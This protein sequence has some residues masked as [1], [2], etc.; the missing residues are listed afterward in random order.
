MTRPRRLPL[1]SASTQG[2][3]Q[4]WWT[5]RPPP[6]YPTSDVDT[7]GSLPLPAVGLG[8][9]STVGTP[10][11]TSS[12]SEWTSTGWPGGAAGPSGAN[13]AVDVSPAA[14][15]TVDPDHASAAGPPS[16]HGS[17]PGMGGTPLSWVMLAAEEQAARGRAHA[18]RMQQEARTKAAAPR[19]L[20]AW[21]PAMPAIRE[22][23][24]VDDGPAPPPPPPPLR[25][26][27]VDAPTPSLAADRSRGARPMDLSGRPS[28][29]PAVAAAG[30]AA[31]GSADAVVAPVEGRATTTLPSVDPKPPSSARVGDVDRTFL[32]PCS[33]PRRRPSGR[34]GGTHT[35]RTS[36]SGLA[37]PRGC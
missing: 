37:P 16:G 34:R 12:T 13:P 20:P 21:P 28:A 31:R 10:S 29:A 17:Q 22:Y 15:A 27:D 30:G 6:G 25:P 2:S 24:P 3:E 26:G 18:E 23:N 35:C 11:V 36:S 8:D 14:P 33:L 32:V 4:R 1:S 19:A 9:A 7:F 5:R